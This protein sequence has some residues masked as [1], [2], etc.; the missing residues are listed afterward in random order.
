MQE[1]RPIVAFLFFSDALA[2]THTHTHAHSN[3]MNSIKS[4]NHSF[5]K[6]QIILPSI[7]GDR[8]YSWPTAS[9]KRHEQGQRSNARIESRRVAY[10]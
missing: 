10:E 3:A 2:L 8:N 5:S 9:N 6:L 7:G 1:L 4:N